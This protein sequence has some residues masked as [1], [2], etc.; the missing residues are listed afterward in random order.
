MKRNLCIYTNKY[1]KQLIQNIMDKI[2]S[3]TYQR[4]Q[5]EL[6]LYGYVDIKKFVKKYPIE[7]FMRKNNNDR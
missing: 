7:S 3:I 5:L 1:Q 4:L 6:A 2:N